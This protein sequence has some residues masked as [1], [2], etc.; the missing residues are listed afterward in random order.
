MEKALEVHELRVAVNDKEVVKRASLELR[1][2]ET[3]LLLGPNGSGKTSLLCAI[4]GHPRYKVLSGSIKLFGEV[5]N[6]VPSFERVK[7][8]LALAFQKPPIIKGLR[9]RDLLNRVA[10]KSGCDEK[11]VKEVVQLLSIEHLLDRYYGY[12]FSGGELKRAE[13]ALLLVSK[14]RVALI[15]EPDSGVD[16]D[17]VMIIASALH[18]LRKNAGSSMLIVTHT[19]LISRHVSFDKLYV[20]INGEIVMETSDKMVLEDILSKGFSWVKKKYAK[21]LSS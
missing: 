17:S 15:D 4:A 13:I 7:R 20:M 8:G 5:V 1:E 9:F 10:S 12:G 2:G 19:G 18:E 21:E 14:P 11:F 16:V 6:D 3:A